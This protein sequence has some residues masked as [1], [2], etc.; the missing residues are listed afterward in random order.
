MSLTPGTTV[1]RYEIRVLLGSGGMGEVYQAH[2]PTLGRLV[3][4]KVLRQH[5]SVEAGRLTRFLQEARAASALNHPNILTIHEVGDHEASRFIVSEFVEGT[6]LRDRMERGPLTLREVLDVGIQ[7][8]SALAAAHTAGIVHR[9]I[10]PENLMLRPDGYVKVLDFGVATLARPAD[11]GDDAATMA[12]RETD[13]GMV[14]GTM[15]YMAPEQARGLPVDGRADCFSLG[16]VLYELVTGRTPFAGPTPS[17]VMVAILDKEPPPI[18]QLARGLPLQ[19]EWIISKALDKDPNLRYQSIADLRVD[20]QRLKNAI[21]SGRLI[22]GAIAEAI[23]PRLDDQPLEVELTDDSA[24]V[25]A[26][27]A[28][29]RGTYVLAA[30]ALVAIAAAL[31]AYDRARPGADLPLQLPEG[32]AATKARDAVQSL[33]YAFSGSQQD[34]DFHRTIDLKDVVTL[35]GLPA[36]REAIHDGVVAQWAVGLT[37]ATNPGTLTNDALSGLIDAEPKEGEFAIRM[38]PRGEL[39]GF[40]TGVSQAASAAPDRERATALG[41]ETLRRLFKVDASG[42]QLEYITREFPAS[43][44][45]MTWRNPVPR[46]GH[47]EQ[48]RVNL[49]GDKVVRADRSFVLPR[50]YKEPEPSAV[51]RGF[52]VSGPAVVIAGF[53][54]AWG[55]GIWVVIKA[56]NWDVL[57]H[58]LPIAICAMLVVSAALS[59]IDSASL[60]QALLG[61]AALAI[62]IAGTVLPALSG[63]LLWM[64]RRHPGRLWAIDQLSRGN[65]FTSAVSIS[66]L[67]GVAAGAA[68]AATSVFADL[69]AL[70]VPGFLPSISR[71]IGA[72]NKGLGSIVSDAINM[73]SFLSIGIALAVEALDKFRVR[74]AVATLIIAV[75]A[76]LTVTGDQEAMVAALLPAA[77]MA[78][79]AAIT[80][81]LYRRRGLLAAWTASAVSSLLVAAMAARSLDDAD[82]VKRGNLAIA[83]AF[84]PIV[85]GIWALIKVRTV[86]TVR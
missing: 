39:T 6:T 68:M 5:L 57:R 30:V 52:R 63:V 24:P 56:K 55:F 66:L 78:V 12:P 35:A 65:L 36:G 74:P 53:L 34:V 81:T 38:D 51:A 23:E 67:A 69:G 18:R 61:V 73:A 9:D 28:L 64:R 48:L 47:I 8:A 41:L 80:V 14:V 3:A 21:D 33:G 11:H 37:Q 79:G 44:V 76:A 32:A 72:V 29:T 45:E 54:A 1:G 4:L 50:G 59:T 75:A 46:F 13:A 19:L 62:L 26:L 15:A 84:I 42:H 71:E 2:D 86:R 27:S 16:V 10:K 17:D 60:W 25:Q 40:L 20:L 58:R 22:E 7:T 43:T 49:Q 31:F 77:G 82:L 83:V 70:Q 85:L